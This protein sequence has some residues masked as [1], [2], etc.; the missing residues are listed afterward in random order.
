LIRRATG[1]WEGTL[2]IKVVA[3]M[4][5]VLVVGLVVVGLVVGRVVAGLVVEAVQKD[6]TR[7]A[8]RSRGEGKVPLDRV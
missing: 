6:L 2:V 1:L 7:A 8:G 4:I 3:L 5:A